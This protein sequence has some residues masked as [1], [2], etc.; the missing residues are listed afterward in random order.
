MRITL[1][2]SILILCLVIVPLEGQENDVFI[3]GDFRDV[4]FEE[5]VG[6]VEQ[7]SGVQFYY[8]EEWVKGIRVTIAGQ[9]ISLR[10]IL[11][12]TLLPTGLSYYL[13][14][15]RQVFITNQSPLVTK[16]PDYSRG[17]G[18]LTGFP[19]EELTDDL[20]ST[21]KKYI[22]GRRAGML[23]TIQVGNRESGN[24]VTNAVLHGKITDL[25]TGEPL[26]GAT[27]YLEELKKG[28]A[29]DVDGRFSM[30]VRPGMYTVD[31]NCMGMEAKR[32][33]LEV[34]SGG[35]LS[36]SMEKSL[37]SL[38]EVVIQANRYHNVRGTQ[39]GF[40]RLN[41]KVMKEVPV[42]MGEKDVLKIV[43]ML[44]GVQSVGEGAAGFNV[45]GSAADQNMI[46]VN[47]VP[48]YN[49]SHL[50]GFFTSFSPDIVK[51]FTLYKSN[52]PASFGGR[53]ASFF[54]ISTRQGNMNEYT[55]R[56]GISPVTGHVAVEGPIRKDKSA[57]VLSA[58]ST[59]SDWIL[60]R[61]EDPD[62]R[63][64]E[65]GFFDLAG[66]FTW[67]PG[68]KTLVKAFGYMSRD[69]FTLG[70]AN[71]YNY[72]NAGAS[73]NVRH[74]FNTR[75]SGDLALVYGEYD[76]R[77]VDQ[78]VPSESYSHEYRISHYELKSDFTW[79]SL[80]SHKLTFGGNAIFYDLDRG[81][82]EPY[83]AYS[84]R[85]PVPLGTDNGVETAIYIA[86]EIML[87]P[88][89]TLYGGLRYSLFMSMG[90]EQVRIYA[91]DQPLR[92]DNI[93]DE[94]SF[95]RGEVIR[96]YSSLEPRVALNYIIGKNNSVKAS[97]NRGKQYLFMLSN[98][99][100][101]SPTDQWK[102][103]DY[104]IIPPYVDQLSVGYYQ[105]LPSRGLSTSLE[106]YHKWVSN[107]VDYREGANFISSPYIET[108][109]LQGKQV[110]Y[111]AEA[112]VKKSAGKLNGWLAYSYSRSFMQIDSP[113]PGE[114]I[115]EGDPYPSNYD[116]PHNVSV[117]ANY[118][119]NRRLSF[120]AN[121]VYITGRPV[122]YPVSIYYLEGM[123]Y[124]DYS[125][126]NTYRIPDY[127]RVDF[128]INLE[129]N[130]KE[131]KLFHS[132]WMLNFYNLTGRENAYSVYFQNDDGVINGY[133]LSIFGRPVVTLSWNFK[134]GNYAS[135]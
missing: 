52:L 74:R 95:G 102:L 64:S 28:A 42:V 31:F 57:F 127:F 91:E 119:I 12:R 107:V 115:N 30:V 112:M 32:N 63:D 7:Q 17:T 92:P 60:K 97:Y 24:G 5:F 76:F 39:M 48:V 99:I 111:G 19:G 96:S 54:D 128:S 40:D 2:A 55:A 49:S 134:L 109:I 4:T 120:S 18:G 68:E 82:V 33:Y 29:T 121:M 130:L 98:T 83:G 125:A 123:Q 10:K 6:R 85:I 56:G 89:L 62:L 101:I 26:I 77:N 131:R 133:K 61:L 47:K 23:E 129:G 126:R 132:Y 20:T 70:D 106:L 67:E 38:T 14:E 80:G 135:E 105:D 84:L 58:R 113:I 75:I 25:E 43:Q 37:I 124:I 11:D 27:I 65:A 116:R 104:H 71:R 51:D 108:E 59:Y 21:E 81:T 103:C 15:H 88:Q 73:V 110:A 114:S 66:A 122:T 1:P 93:I 90:P 117:V 78:N 16:L 86:D 87:L 35:D 53:L 50:F 118:K 41:Y 34:F 9:E 13:D 8:L 45:R 46:Y 69:H 79:L 36:I 94:I 44:P 22:E 72:S 3:S 100:A